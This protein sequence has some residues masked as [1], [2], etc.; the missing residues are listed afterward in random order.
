MLFLFATLALAAAPDAE[1]AARVRLAEDPTDASRWV[2]LGEA[3]DPTEAEPLYREAIR[4]EPADEAAWLGLGRALLA[5]G[6]SSAAEAAFAKALALSPGD[7]RAVVGRAEALGDP[8]LADAAL[9]QFPADPRAQ[10]LVARLEPSRAMAV[11]TS[12]EPA[13]RL[14]RADVLLASGDD[15]TA[16]LAG[17]TGPEADRLGDWSRCELAG[18]ADAA[19]YVAF[20]SARR[21]A[22]RGVRVD[23]GPLLARSPECAAAHALAAA[24]LGDPAEWRAA[25]ALSPGEASLAAALGH[26][27]LVKGDLPA[28][29]LAL[30][31]SGLADVDAALDRAELARRTGDRVQARDLL[32]AAAEKFPFDARIALARADLADDQEARLDILLDGIT[33]THDPR[34]VEAASAIAR[35]IGRAPD[36]AAALAPPVPERGAEEP[37]PAA[38]EIVVWGEKDSDQR[39]EE[40]EARLAALGYGR[41]SVRRDGTVFYP[42]GD[43]HHPWLELHPDGLVDIQRAGRFPVEDVHP[44]LLAMP[45]PDGEEALGAGITGRWTRRNERQLGAERWALLENVRPELTSWREALCHEGFETRLVDQIPASL[46]ALWHEGVALDGG[47]NL[48]DPPARREAILDYWATRTCTPEGDQVRTVIARY[49][50]NEVQASAWPV[51][52]EELAAANARRACPGS[53]A[54]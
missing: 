4:I 7:P 11:L 34:L 38:Q 27:L 28:A 1:Y 31:D 19:A 2:A 43:V 47:P 6:Q 10:L 18:T 24:I 40:L 14:A 52:P 5:S 44:G 17:L 9:Q 23:V 46:D 20:S 33:R 53:L 3:V 39:L 49:L 42:S 22:L 35:S 16:E 50:V 30:A 37:E 21:D 41:P 8:A 12:D 13:V 36:L 32:A 15:A 25:L 29:K 51:T 45:G 26:A 48:A 54:L